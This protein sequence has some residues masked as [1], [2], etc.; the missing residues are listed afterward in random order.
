[1][2]PPPTARLRFR[3]MSARDLPQIET[4]EIGG[5]RG[6]GGWIDWNRRNYEQ[7][8]FGLWVI[9]THAGEF[10]GDCGLTVQEVEGDHLIEIGWHVRASLRRQGFATE[11]ASS[12]RDTAR[13][14]GITHLVAIIRPTNVA[15]QHVAANIGLVLER[16]VHAH[17]AP[18]LV[19]GADLKPQATST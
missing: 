19:W 12:V 9:E 17:G 15:S 7:H 6:P 3:E 8:G 1:M 18:A 2:L 14:A 11:A 16:E 13:D 4:L 5:S 10:V